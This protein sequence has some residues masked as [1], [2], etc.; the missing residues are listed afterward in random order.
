MTYLFG[1]LLCLPDNTT[2]ADIVMLGAGGCTNT[3]RIFIFIRINPKFSDNSCR[4]S[5]DLQY[6]Q[7]HPQLDFCRAGNVMRKGPITAGAER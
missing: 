6:Q 3:I 2:N 1:W 4:N 5:T 7:R